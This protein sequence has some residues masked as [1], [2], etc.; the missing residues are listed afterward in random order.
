MVKV[1]RRG[2][3][4]NYIGL[5]TINIAISIFLS[6]VSP[7]FLNIKNFI[8]IGNQIAIN[9]L[10][11]VGMTLLICSGGIDLSV[12]SNVALTG[13]VSAIF[14]QNVNTNTITILLG[15]ILGLVTGVMIGLINGVLVS[16]LKVP[17]F[18]ATLGTMGVFRGLALIFSGGRPLMGMPDSFLS[19]F[20]GF[21]AGIPKPVIAAIVVS[22]VGVY[23]MNKTILGRF[24]KAIGGNEKCVQVC[25]VSIEKYKIII[26]TLE[27]GLGAVSGLALTS[28][29]ATA[30]PIAGLWY[31]LEAIAVVV[32]GGTSLRGGKASIL[33]TV[34]AALLL[35]I[36]RNGLNIMMVPANYHQ[37]LVGVIIFIAITI[38]GRQ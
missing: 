29:M 27:G 22:F 30:E 16:T 12:G 9:L 26:Y 18:I 20:S 1:L 34:L 37:L 2:I 28:M 36:V 35:G 21:L 10:I 17:P 13:V 19:I 38:S 25:G 7:Y 4:M 11:A 32:M 15:L 23:L 5:L 6:L 14:F 8:N 33:G 3:P 31:E 24:I